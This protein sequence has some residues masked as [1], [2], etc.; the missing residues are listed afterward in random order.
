M[1]IEQAITNGQ[2]TEESYTRYKQ[3]NPDDW[4]ITTFKQYPDIVTDEKSTYGGIINY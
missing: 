1:K 3:I 4:S 2:F